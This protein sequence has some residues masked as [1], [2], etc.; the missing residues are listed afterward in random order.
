MTKKF[1]PVIA[2]KIVLTEW[3]NSFKNRPCADCLK[4]YPPYVMDFDHLP[5]FSKRFT[6]SQYIR[7]NG[8]KPNARA[9]L[10]AEI[11]KCQPVCAN[12][13]RERTH[14]RAV[15]AAQARKLKPKKMKVL[16]PWLK[17]GYDSKFE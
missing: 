13:H 7:E 8:H 2:Q 15:K 5:G 1:N 3:V 10:A 9:L 16:K 12:C 4:S 6:I 17:K 11:A 14:K